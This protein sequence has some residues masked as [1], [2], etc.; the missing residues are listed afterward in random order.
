MS[1]GSRVS[2]TSSN[3]LAWG[4]MLLRPSK[5]LMKYAIVLSQCVAV[6]FVLFPH[7]RVVWKR[8]QHYVFVDERKLVKFI[9]YGLLAL[10]ILFNLYATILTFVSIIRF[11]HFSTSR[12]YWYRWLS[13]EARRDFF[14][15][16]VTFLVSLVLDRALYIVLSHLRLQEQLIEV[17]GKDPEAQPRDL[18]SGSYPLQFFLYLASVDVLVLASSEFLYKPRSLQPVRDAFYNARSFLGLD[19]RIRLPSSPTSEVHFKED[20]IAR[21]ERD[22]AELRSALA[23][24]ASPTGSDKTVGGSTSRQVPTDVQ[25]LITSQEKEI[26]E[27]KSVVREFSETLKAQAASQAAQYDKLAAQYTQLSSEGKGKGK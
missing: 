16:G 10:L 6:S 22:I 26:S 1:I 27:L 8:I 4:V 14:L 12:N 24:A 20:V 18:S 7:P 21:Q 15:S 13:R 17:H 25:A 23:R 5:D 19:P 3:P 2:T 11:I 9:K